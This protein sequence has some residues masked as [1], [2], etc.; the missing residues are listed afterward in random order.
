MRRNIDISKCLLQKALKWPYK[1]SELGPRHGGRADSM[2]KGLG[3]SQSTAEKEREVSPIWELLLW[4]DTRAKSSVGVEGLIWFSF[5]H[6]RS[7]KEVGTKPRGRN[8]VHSL[9]ELCLL[10]CVTGKF[11]HL[12][13]GKTT[14]SR[15]GYQLLIKKMPHRS[16]H[17]LI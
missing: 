7:W 12:P 2:Y 10:A 6:S 1:V 9:K 13:R 15:L 3:L 11:T 14:Y 5:D 8:W 4:Y 16:A 17:G